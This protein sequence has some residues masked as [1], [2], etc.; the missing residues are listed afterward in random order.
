MTWREQNDSVIL[1]PRG[2]LHEGDECDALERG[3]ESLL[4]RG[5]REVVIDLA[6]TGHLSAHAIGILA[7][8]Q[9]RMLARGGRL[10]LRGVHHDQHWLLEVTH[11]G[12]ALGIGS[13]WTRTSGDAT[14]P[15][16]DIPD[17]AAP[18][19]HCVLRSPGN[20]GEASSV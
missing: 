4:E 12:D 19:G 5:M 18:R 3:L 2:N 20:R 1:T 7:R 14:E 6:E 10:A 8:A 16:V 15:G 9:S 11:T 13:Q 17:A